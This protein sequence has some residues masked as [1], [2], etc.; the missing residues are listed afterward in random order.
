LSYRGKLASAVAVCV[1][2]LAGAFALWACG[3]DLP[4]WI[5]DDEAG[6]LEAP[7]IWLR[8][9]L[10]PLLPPGKPTFPAVTSLPI[11]LRGPPGSTRKASR[12]R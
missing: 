4:H 10:D 6:I 1:L 5:L 7:T 2:P 12:K 8:N 11:P 3:P 9:A